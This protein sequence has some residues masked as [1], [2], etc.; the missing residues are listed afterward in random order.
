[1]S[2]KSHLRKAYAIMRGAF[3]RWAAQQTVASVEAWG[4]LLDDIDPDLLVSAVKRLARIATFPPEV[5]RIREEANREMRIQ[6][7]LASAAAHERW[8]AEQERRAT[9]EA[10]ARLRAAGIDPTSINPTSI[11]SLIGG[12]GR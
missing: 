11:A 1:M 7:S 4:E 8:V 6:A 12:I 10:E 9:E 3:P 2:D 5:A